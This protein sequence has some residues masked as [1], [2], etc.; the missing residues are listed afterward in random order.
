MRRQGITRRPLLK[1]ATL[2]PLAGLSRSAD[3][4]GPSVVVLGTGAFRGFT[5][6]QLLRRGARVT[7]IDTWGPGNSRAGS[8]ARQRA[9]VLC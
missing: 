8:T 2:G 4:K 5:A 7:F 3:A 9:L 6:L 1:A